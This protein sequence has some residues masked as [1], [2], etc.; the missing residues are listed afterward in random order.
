MNAIPTKL[1]NV[2]ISSLPPDQ[3]LG[4]LRL[5]LDADIDGDVAS[6]LDKSRTKLI[7]DFPVPVGRWESVDCP[8]SATYLNSAHEL[9]SCNRA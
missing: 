2:F 5:G 6:D 4:L 3:V 9:H 1:W 7:C 8:A